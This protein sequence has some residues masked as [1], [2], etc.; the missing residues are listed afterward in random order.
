VLAGWAGGTPAVVGVGVGVTAAG[1]LL[2]S[3]RRRLGGFTGDVLGAT[4][5]VSETVAL[6]VAGV[7][8]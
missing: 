5:V 2:W 7:H 6:L 8:W 4:V 1:V 3:A